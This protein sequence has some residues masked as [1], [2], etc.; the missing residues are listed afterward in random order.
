MEIINLGTA[1]GL[2][3]ARI[4]EALR[5][6]MWEKVGV[7]KDEASL[8]SALADIEHLKA[9]MLPRLGIA[10]KSRIANYEWLDAID[11]V[12]MIEACELIIHSARERRESRGPFMRRD[13]PAMDNG[14]W[15]VANLMIRTEDGFR[16][17]RRPYEL[18]FLKP[19]FA[20][21]DNLEV[22]W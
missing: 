16:F 6:L 9:E 13:F 1:D 21:R 12:N 18:P 5:R 7:E 2:P 17:E 14:A 15:L 8:H 11:L 3:P 22:P 4:K 20:V 10:H 19:D